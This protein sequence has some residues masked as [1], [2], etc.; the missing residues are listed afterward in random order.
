MKQLLLSAIV[1]VVAAIGFISC[2]D[3]NDELAT[4]TIQETQTLDFKTTLSLTLDSFGLKIG[5]IKTRG[6]VHYM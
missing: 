2:N 3:H 4:T 6:G 1:I 5:Y